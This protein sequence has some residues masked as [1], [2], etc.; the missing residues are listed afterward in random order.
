MDTQHFTVNNSID[1]L[2]VSKTAMQVWFPFCNCAV[3]KKAASVQFTGLKREKAIYHY[4]V[5][6]NFPVC[7]FFKTPIADCCFAKHCFEHLELLVFMTPWNGYYCGPQ[8]HHNLSKVCAEK[9]WLRHLGARTENFSF[10]TALYHGTTVFA[11][12]RN[13]TKLHVLRLV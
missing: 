1:I 6:T 9:T 8:K 4:Q 12:S 7:L 3:T 2:E 11:I 5:T 13:F 10:P